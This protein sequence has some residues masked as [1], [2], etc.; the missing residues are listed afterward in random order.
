MVEDSIHEIWDQSERLARATI[1]NIPDGEYTAESYLDDDYADTTKTLPVKVKV[2]VHGDEMTVDFSGLPD[3]TRG[4]LNSGPSGGVAAARVAYKMLVTP[5]G[6]VTEGEFRPLKV[7]LPPGKI[8]SAVHPAPMAFWSSSMPT[9]IDTT[10][11]AMAD[12]LPDR[13]PAGHKGD[14]AG[15]ALFG[16]DKARNGRRFVCTNIFGGGFGAKSSGDGVSA[17][18]SLCQGGV[19]NAPVEVQEAYYPVFI[20]AHRMRIDSGGAG[21]FRGG[22]GVELVISSKQDFFANTHLQRTKLPPWGLHGGKDALAMGGEVI[23]TDGKRI[24]GA[25]LDNARVAPGD[26]LTVLAG[27][28]GGWG[29]AWE[30]PAER[31]R[32]DV[33]EGLVSLEAARRD[34]GVAL[35]PKTYAIDAAATSKLRAEMAKAASA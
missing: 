3:Q 34:Y 28:G 27:G 29:P 5:H 11:K 7:I 21:K 33:I 14:M 10:L 1:T 8:L 17:V 24:P 31:V 16:E 9:I 2:I 12:V 18:V 13:I 26:K 19:H 4:P 22:L 25:R 23:T 32:L 6:M 35:D 20:E 30:R 15:L